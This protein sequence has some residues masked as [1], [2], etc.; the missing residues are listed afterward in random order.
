MHIAVEVILGFGSE[1]GRGGK[2]FPSDLIFFHL[3]L[4][5]YQF[6][7]LKEQIKSMEQHYTIYVKNYKEVIIE[8]V[9]MC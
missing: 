8:G 2:I 6:I 5:T 1:G 7:N 4:S 9:V 3:Y